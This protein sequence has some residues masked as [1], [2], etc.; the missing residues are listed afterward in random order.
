[1][2]ITKLTRLEIEPSGLSWRLIEKGCIENKR[3]EIINLKKTIQQDL[4]DNLTNFVN[5]L[6]EDF[7]IT[8][9]NHLVKLST[10]NITIKT[11]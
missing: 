5:N 7:N 4:E 3:S 8:I 6:K 2:T 9:N 1:M 10:N 11:N